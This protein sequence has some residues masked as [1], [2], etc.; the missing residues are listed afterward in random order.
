[1]VLDTSMLISSITPLHQSPGWSMPYYCKWIVNATRREVLSIRA[2]PTVIITPSSHRWMD[3][4]RTHSNNGNYNWPHLLPPNQSPSFNTSEADCYHCTF[5]P[6]LD[7]Q[8]ANTFKQRRCSNKT[9]R[10]HIY[11][12]AQY[13]HFLLTAWASWLC[14]GWKRVGFVKW[15]SDYPLL[16]D[17]LLPLNAAPLGVHVLW[18]GG[19]GA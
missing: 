10:I 19:G 12:I 17:H 18:V 9:L 14:A 2:K 11:T 3:K 1:M 4:P 7:G 13:P 8:A 15:F 6:P 16:T 5:F